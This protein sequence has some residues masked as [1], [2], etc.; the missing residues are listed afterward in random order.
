MNTVALTELASRSLL[1]KVHLKKNPEAE[2]LDGNRYK[3]KFPIDYRRVFLIAVFFRVNFCGKTPCTYL[4]H[5]VLLVGVTDP[6]NS[7]AFIFE[8]WI[9]MGISTFSNAHN[10]VKNLVWT[11]FYSPFWSSWADLSFAP[12]FRVW[13]QILFFLLALSVKATVSLS[14]SYRSI[15]ILKVHFDKIVIKTWR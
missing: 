7:G 8:S 5:T 15:F 14:W 2:K 4:H 11:S 3:I 9:Y 6:G 12:T 10:F 1:V 13:R